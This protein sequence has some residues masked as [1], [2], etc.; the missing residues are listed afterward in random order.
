METTQVSLYEW[1]DKYV[2][3]PSMGY[4]S[5]AKGSDTL[6]KATWVNSEKKILSEGGQTQKGKYYTIL[7]TW[8]DQ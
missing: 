6:I 3:L 7:R 1:K 8:S 4:Y 5:T 2:V